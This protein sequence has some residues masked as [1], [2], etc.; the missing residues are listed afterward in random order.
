MT[1]SRP[2][3]QGFAIN[4]NTVIAGISTLIGGIV[5]YMVTTGMGEVKST[6]IDVKEVKT[7]MPYLQHS[8]DTAQTDIKESH[9]EL[10]G[11][12]KEI[13]AEQMKVREDL[14]KQA[15]NLKPHE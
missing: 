8:V 15:A 11:D 1:A 6:A 2:Q 12:I 10:K 14:M 9:R 7:Q 5:L 4:T 13:Q 3:P